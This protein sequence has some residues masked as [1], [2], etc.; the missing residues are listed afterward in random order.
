[1]IIK[2][3]HPSPFSSKNILPSKY[4]SS[5]TK[6]YAEDSGLPTTSQPR[7]WSHSS[8][9]C[10]WDS[11]R[12]GIKSSSTFQISQGE[13]TGVTIS[14]PYEWLSML[15]A[16]S[17]ESISQI[18][19]TRNNSCLHNLNFFYLSRSSSD[20]KVTV[21]FITNI[22]PTTYHTTNNHTNIP[23]NHTTIPYHSYL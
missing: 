4:R 23:Y 19:C 3:V 22:Q 7:E 20:L 13:P 21:Y 2:N 12:D 6:T 16:A 11:T 9:L 8:A 5:T 17:E 1:M 14:R 10:P 18:D 15:I